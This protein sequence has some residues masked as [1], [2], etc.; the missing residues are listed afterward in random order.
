MLPADRSRRKGAP[1]HRATTRSR[2][3]RR[4]LLRLRVSRRPLLLLGLCGAL[5][6][7]EPVFLDALLAD[8]TVTPSRATQVVW[9][10]YPVTVPFV[11]A[12]T[13]RV[14]LDLEAPLLEGASTLVGATILN[15]PERVE[16][17]DT[18]LV[19]I[20]LTPQA[21]AEGVRTELVLTITP[22]DDEVAPVTAVLEVEVRAPPPCEARDPCETALFDATLGECVRTAHPDGEACSD[23]S[24][25]TEDDRCS[26]GTCLGRAVTCGDLVDCTID[27]CDPSRGCVFEPIDARCEDDNPCTADTCVATSGCVRSVVQDGTPCGPFSCAQLETCF[28]GVCVAAPTPDGF[29]CED[30]DLCTA[31]DSCLAQ[32]CVSGETVAPTAQPPSPLARPTLHVEEDVR[33]YQDEHLDSQPIDP[34]PGFD[35]TLRFGQALDVT[36]G[37]VGWR[38]TLA[39]LWKSEPFGQGGVPCS[40]W[41]MWAFTRTAYDPGF[42]ATAVVVTVMDEGELAR[43]EGG[44]SIVVGLA[45]GT[46]D[47]SFVRTDDDLMVDDWV[48]SDAVQVLVAESTYAPR[49]DPGREMRIHQVDVSLTTRSVSARSTSYY[50]NGPRWQVETN[51]HAGLRVADLDGAPSVVGWDLPQWPYQPADAPDSGGAGDRE[52]DPPP[53]DGGAAQMPWMETTLDTGFISAA[54]PPDGYGQF[55]WSPIIYDECMEMPPPTEELAFRDVDVFRYE[56][57][58]WAVARHGLLGGYADGCSEYAEPTSASLFPLAFFDIADEVPWVALGDDVLS[59]SITPRAEE[60]ALVRPNLCTD[61]PAFCPAF[62]LQVM[63]PP[64]GALDPV[65]TTWSVP[66][67]DVGV[68]AVDAL[69]LEPRFGAVGAVALVRDLVGTTTVTLYDGVDTGTPLVLATTPFTVAERPARALRSPL[70]PQSVY[71]VVTVPPPPTADGLLHASEGAVVRFGCPFPSF[72][73][74][75]VP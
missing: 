27:T 67:G 10:G 62:A 59:V 36:Q 20:A 23:G 49:P 1:A 39:V 44:T 18:A 17:A 34:P 68:V 19:D 60:L 25:C 2:A 55:G 11:L 69:A 5:A 37:L 6:A 7:C 54:A 40:P 58:A 12:N 33:W 21:G 61:V 51:V 74:V 8:L 47:A 13:S 65:V 48:P 66:L 72:P 22:V 46:V 28:Y 71:A 63:A 73:S 50:Y 45:Y 38:P 53:P 26:S 24:L 29:P 42:C 56:G 3:A 64:L 70:S 52:A 15:A 57:M 4:L 43:A 32:A 31:G 14:G 30:G 35:T 41:D 16:S 9:I 75:V